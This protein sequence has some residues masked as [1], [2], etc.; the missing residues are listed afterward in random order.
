MLGTYLWIIVLMTFG[1]WILYWRKKRKFD[2]TNE[3]G[4][5]VFSSYRK[6]SITKIFDGVLLWVGCGAIIVSAFLIMTLD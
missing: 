6:K 5:E 3:Q 1:G 4:V 2:R